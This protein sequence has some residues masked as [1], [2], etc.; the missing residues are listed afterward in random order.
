MAEPCAIACSS[1]PCGSATVADYAAT[2]E[3]VLESRP[4]D[5]VI[6]PMAVADFE[7][8]PRP[9][10]ISSDPETLVVA[11]PPHAQGDPLGSRLVS[12]G[13]PGR[14]QAAVARCSAKS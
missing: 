9:G 14:V 8:E 12:L 1:F 3:Q 2:L 13:L 6:L 7:P 11:L 10:K 5:V 4:I